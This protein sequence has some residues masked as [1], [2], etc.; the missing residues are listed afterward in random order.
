MKT[1]PSRP[2]DAS[3]SRSGLWVLFLH[4]V[5]ILGF[6]FAASSNPSQALF[7]NDGPLGAQVSDIYKMPGAFHSI[8]S[9]LYWVGSYGGNYAPNATG[10]L[11]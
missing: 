8:W 6:S 11:L 10:L 9:N 1:G 3:R 5:L 7:A 2:R 4:L